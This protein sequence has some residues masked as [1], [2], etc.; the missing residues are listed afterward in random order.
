MSST[1]SRIDQLVSIV[2][3]THNARAWILDTL[4]SVLTQ[5]Y[6]HIELI[7]VDDGST[8]DTAG[9]VRR[10]LAA[11]FRND[12]R[13]IE[14]GKNRG[15]SVARNIGLAAARGGWIQ[16]LDSDDFIA[17]EK[18]A[19]Q[20]MVCAGAPDDV[21]AVYSPWRRCYF[22]GGRVKWTTP[23]V[24]PNMEGRAPIMCMVSNERPLQGAG[25]ARR[26][27]LEAIGGF[28]ETL[29]FWECEELTVRL[30]KTGRLVN[31]PSDEAFYLWREHRDRI[32]IG[33]ANARYHIANVALGWIEQMVRAAEGRSLD[34]LALSERDR[35]DILFQCTEY[36]RWLFSKDRRA[37][38][39]YVQMA[40]IFDPN[41]APAHPK[42]ATTLSHWLG[43]EA[44]EGVTRLS[45]APAALLRR[46]A[47]PA[48][49]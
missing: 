47:S 8:D 21:T 35:R 24:Q 34:D 38:R 2:I 44:A 41:L 22:E 26:S 13:V 33:G 6:P 42:L 7:V 18:I 12:W 4:S 16:F 25:L 5:T 39:R 29:R 36:G 32:Y 17:P 20:M 40:R 23:L 10:R 48:I 28:D 37:F 27:A 14:I 1:L 15:P 19:R 3:P 11:D 45:R 43:Y 9:I 30:A 31:V 49:S 46:L